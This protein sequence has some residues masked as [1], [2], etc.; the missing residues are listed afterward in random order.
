[1]PGSA[2]MKRKAPICS[3]QGEPS[4]PRNLSASASNVLQLGCSVAERQ[5]LGR[6]Y[7]PTQLKIIDKDHSKQA[8]N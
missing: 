3:F 7:I 6:L 4:F 2:Y 1:M 8:E 5:T